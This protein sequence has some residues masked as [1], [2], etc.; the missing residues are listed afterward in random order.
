MSS[1]CITGRLASNYTRA[2]A[3]MREAYVPGS[4]WSY[5]NKFHV[6][7]LFSFHYHLYIQSFNVNNVICFIQFLV[8][9]RLSTLTIH[10]Y[11]SAIK[12]RLSSFGFDNSIWSHHRVLVMQKACSMPEQWLHST[13]PSMSLLLV[14]WPILFIGFHFIQRAAYSRPCFVSLPWFL[15]DIKFTP[16][17]RKDYSV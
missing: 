16:H 17:V 14:H 5:Y 7:L 10:T 13:S 15:Q 1:S 3:R 11:L 9:S 12:S 6:L 4:Q 2:A 8:D